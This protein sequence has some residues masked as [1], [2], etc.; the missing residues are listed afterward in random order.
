MTLR[1]GKNKVV[2][3]VHL[4]LYDNQDFMAQMLSNSQPT[5]VQWQVLFDT[6]SNIELD[7][8]DLINTSK[9]MFVIHKLS[10]GPV[11]NS[12][13][14]M[15]YRRIRRLK[16]HSSKSNNLKSIRKN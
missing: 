6:S 3:P 10:I 13:L 2:L 1:Y 9:M 7:Y 5:P 14:R 12:Y 11:I 4:Q 8:L 15:L 16:P